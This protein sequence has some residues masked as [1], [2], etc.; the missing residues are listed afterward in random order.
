MGRGTWVHLLLA[1]WERL[2]PPGLGARPAGLWPRLP[3]GQLEGALGQLRFY[4]P[5]SSCPYLMAK[6]FSFSLC[7]CDVGVALGVD[8]TVAGG[9]YFYSQQRLKTVLFCKTTPGAILVE[10][11]WFQK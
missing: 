8:Y 10:E 5:E 2:H 3:Q 6:P 4:R 11:R 1:I 9:S 7:I